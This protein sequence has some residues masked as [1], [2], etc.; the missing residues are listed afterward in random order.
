MPVSLAKTMSF[1]HDNNAP[2]MYMMSLHIK[3]F[4]MIELVYLKKDQNWQGKKIQIAT[5]LQ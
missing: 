5:K 2:D 4:I 3:E 1:N